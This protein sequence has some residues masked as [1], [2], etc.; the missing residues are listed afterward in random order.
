MSTPVDWLQEDDPELTEERAQEIIL[1]NKTKA[2]TGTSRFAGLLK[3]KNES[4]LND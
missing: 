4:N 1:E 2:Q 3:N